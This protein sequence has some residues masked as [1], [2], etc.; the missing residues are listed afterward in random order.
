MTGG[1]EEPCVPWSH[2]AYIQKHSREIEPGRPERL[3]PRVPLLPANVVAG[4]IGEAMIRTGGDGPVLAKLIE[5]ETVGL[6]PHEALEVVSR[7]ILAIG[8]EHVSLRIK[9][10]R[11]ARG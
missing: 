4:R 5:C 10:M 9:Q 7:A 3:C 2:I 6:A 1:A 8:T 11:E